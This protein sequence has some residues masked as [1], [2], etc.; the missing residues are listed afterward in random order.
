MDSTETTRN[1][2]RTSDAAVRAK[3][4]KSWPEWFAILDAVGGM[5]MN[6][7]ELVAHLRER[8]E[9]DGWWQQNVAVAYEQERGLREKH[10]MPDGYQIS[11]SKTIAASA[12]TLHAAWT[13]QELRRR[14]LPDAE[15]TLRKETPGKSLRLN[16][17][18]GATRLDVAFYSKGPNKTQVTVQHNRLVDGEAAERM[19]RYW[20]EALQRLKEILS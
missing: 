5:R 17:G 10:Q 15:V 8:Y 6:H 7:K 2:T 3:T 14:W 12:A 1:V 18:D 16:W 11:V 9:L 20:A 19:K 4:G 13:D